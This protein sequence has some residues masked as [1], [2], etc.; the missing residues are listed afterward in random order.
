MSFTSHGPLD[1]ISNIKYYDEK[2]LVEHHDRS[3]HCNKPPKLCLRFYQ[4]YI[5]NGRTFHSLEY[6]KRGTSNSYFVQYLDYSS[7][8]KLSFGET[9]VFFQDQVDAYALIKQY[10]I[11]QSFSDYFKTSS[12][13][14]MIREPL[15]NFFFILISSENYVCVSIKSIVKHCIV[16]AD[17]SRKSVIVTPIS[18][19]EEHD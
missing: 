10:F 6:N 5:I 15:D 11:K 4:R 8:C 16:F 2:V 1:L 17:A 14:K 12:Y 13:Y 19:Y 18:S 3:C 7:K 9:V